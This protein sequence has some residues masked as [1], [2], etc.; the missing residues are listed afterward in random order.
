[1]VLALPV[2]EGA[3]PA[4]RHRR[5]ETVNSK[6]AVQNVAELFQADDRGAVMGGCPNVSQAQPTRHCRLY[7][8]LGNWP[9]GC[10]E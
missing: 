10:S 7:S 3:L 5:T 6:V 1:M 8:L 4:G 2:Q 9:A